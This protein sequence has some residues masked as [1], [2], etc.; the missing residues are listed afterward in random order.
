MEELSYPGYNNFE[1]KKEC[2]CFGDFLFSD[3]AF[4]CIN[5][6]VRVLFSKLLKTR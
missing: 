3:K 2:F 5:L 6:W 1:N 4:P